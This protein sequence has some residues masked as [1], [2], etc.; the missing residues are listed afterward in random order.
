[1]PS[2]RDANSGR[3][4]PKPPPSRIWALNEP[5]FEGIKPV[6]RDGYQRSNRNTALVIDMGPYPPTHRHD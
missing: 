5:P 6:D 4:S 3:N 2:A 1:M